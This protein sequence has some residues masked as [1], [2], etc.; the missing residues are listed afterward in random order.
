[1]KAWIHST[2]YTV[3]VHAGDDGIIWSISSWKTL[4]SLV[5][6]EHSLL[7]FVAERVHA[8]MTTVYF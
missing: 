2:L 4:G 1:M 3:I 7:E 8:F 5:L 6:T